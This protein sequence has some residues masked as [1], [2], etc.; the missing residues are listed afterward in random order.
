MNARTYVVLKGRCSVLVWPI[1]RLCCLS[2]KTTCIGVVGDVGEFNELT[3]SMIMEEIMLP[4]SNRASCDV[5]SIRANVEH[6]SRL[7]EVAA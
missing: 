5:L 3:K 4:E 6:T 7:E 2:P 1:G